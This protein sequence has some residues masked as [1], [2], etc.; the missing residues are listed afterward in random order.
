[1]ITDNTVLRFNL[2]LYTIR[3]IVE[4]LV[5]IWHRV[6]ARAEMVGAG[7]KWRRE[8]QPASLSGVSAKRRQRNRAYRFIGRRNPMVV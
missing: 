8:F 1:M 3:A 6:Y 7:G 2:D 4:P 5:L